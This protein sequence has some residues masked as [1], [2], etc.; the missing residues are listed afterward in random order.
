MT[1]LKRATIKSYA[2]GTHRAS[3]QIAGSLS[4]WLENVPVATDIPAADVVAGRECAVLFFTDDNPDDAVVVTIHGALPSGGG[5]SDHGALTGLGD[6]DHAQYVVLLGRNPAQTVS[7]GTLSNT[8]LTLRGSSNASPGTDRIDLSS[9]VRL[10]TGKEIQDGGGTRRIFLATAN[11]HVQL[12]GA[13][14]CNIGTTLAAG[15]MSAGP[16]PVTFAYGYFGNLGTGTDGKFGALVDLGAGS[17]AIGGSIAGIAG[18]AY[19]R[20]AAT[21]IVYGLDYVAGGQ[22]AL[23][24]TAYGARTQ[25]ILVGA[26]NVLTDYY[27]FVAKGGFKTGTITN[28]YG[29][30]TEAIGLIATNRFPFYDPETFDGDNNGNRFASNTMFGSIVGAF[31]SGDG[32]IGIANRR[33]APTTNPAGGGILYAEAGALKWRGSAGTVTTLAPA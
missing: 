11:P 14:Y 25:A 24:P 28:W 26:G 33:V 27:G 22:K 30:R 13:V 6:D 10:A 4:V 1:T 15:G 32:V 31:G 3:V 20:D 29:F 21:L 18:R 7:G 17:G 8:V 5:V 19:A 9:D 2:A 23:I 16:A 12:S